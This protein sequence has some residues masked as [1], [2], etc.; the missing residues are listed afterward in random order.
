MTAQHTYE[1]TETLRGFHVVEYSSAGAR[2]HS[3]T[4]KTYDDAW[5]KVLQ[6]KALADKVSAVANVRKRARLR[7]ECTGECGLHMMRCEHRHGAP[8][9]RTAATVDLKVVALDHDLDNHAL[10]NLR[11]YCQV[12]RQHHEADERGSDALF[13]I[14]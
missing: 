7:C 8:L 6:L 4:Y 13:E 10:D 9:P 1:V 14:G 3:K 11:A 5:A 2:F 12:C